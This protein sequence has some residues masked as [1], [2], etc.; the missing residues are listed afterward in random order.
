MGMRWT[1]SNRLA[2]LASMAVVLATPLLAE[3]TSRELKSSASSPRRSKASR[4]GR[5]V[6]TRS[7]SGVR[8]AKSIRAIP[9]TR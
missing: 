5:S 8:S 4:S 1:R 9:A 6:S 2:V 3:R 7:S